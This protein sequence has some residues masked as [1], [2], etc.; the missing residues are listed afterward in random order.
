V[1]EGGVRLHPGVVLLNGVQRPVAED[2]RYD[3]VFSGVGTQM[4]E[5]G[6][7]PKEVAVDLAPGVAKDHLR[8]L[9]GYAQA[10]SWYGLAADQGYADAQ[11]NL[12]VMYNLGRGVPRDYVQAYKWLNLAVSRFSASETE[13]RDNAMKARDVLA[14]KMTP[15]Q[16]AEAQ[17][18]AREWEPK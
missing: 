11:I 10:A 4:E 14:V 18:L 8:D 13:N 2:L 5:P 3:R 9:I 17:R 12:G 15:A 6:N 16:I 7:V 1:P